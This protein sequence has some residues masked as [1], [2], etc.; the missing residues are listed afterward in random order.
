MVPNQPMNMNMMNMNPNQAIDNFKSMMMTMMMVKVSNQNQNDSQSFKYTILTMFIVYF[1]DVIAT[2]LKTICR[3][4]ESKVSQYVSK[5][6]SDISLIKNLH[7]H[8]IKKKKRSSI[9]IKLEPNAKN[10]FSDAIIDLLTHLPDTK[11]ILLQNGQ[12][13]INYYEHIEFQKN[14]FAK[15]TNSSAFYETVT[16]NDHADESNHATANM[17]ANTNVVKI[18][19]PTT[20]SSGSGGEEKAS[21]E[22]KF[23]HIEI[24]SFEYDMETLRHE[25]DTI[26]KH[27]LIKMTNKLGNGI[28]YF[29]ELTQNTPRNAQGNIDYN[30]MNDS[31]IFTM[32][33][34]ETNRSFDNLFG[35][36]ID[37]I[38]KRVNFFRDNK[39]W[40]DQKGIP[41][42]LGILVSGNPGT[43]KT[44][45]IKCISNEMQRHI[46]N[47]HLTDQMSKQ[48]IE[49]LFFNE[50]IK[51][52]Q[53]GHTDIFT[54]PINRR[55]YVLE[56]IDCQCDIVLERSNEENNETLMKNEIHNL[57]Q[58]LALFQ[59]IWDS[60]GSPQATESLF[61][62]LHA[63]EQLPNT[64]KSGENYDNKITLSFLLNLFDG[65]LETP[66]RI[67]FMTTNFADK[68][69][70]AFIRPGRIDVISNFGF[71][72]PNQ[73]RQIVEHRY[74]TVLSE[75]NVDIINH[76]GKC[77][78][79]AEVSKILFQ[80]FDNVQGAINDLKEYSIKFM[81]D[82]EKKLQLQIQNVKEKED[83]KRI[84]YLEAEKEEDTL[85]IEKDKMQNMQN[86]D[87]MTKLLMKLM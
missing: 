3:F 5:R 70:K 86:L 77:I 6:A 76:L 68:L 22:G 49:N 64:K 54:I 84:E 21:G 38:R 71:S 35:E 74:D 83:A 46:I 18:T 53:N 12:F 59:N 20:S 37:I 2:Q 80:N 79:A 17:N 29:N 13:V 10:P 7:I 52:T 36:E 65:V 61:K 9:L 41:Y 27:Y 40:Y 69:D 30:K 48:Q 32:K 78:T 45:L 8:P 55:I 62:K 16:V 11:C 67:I 44:S 42:T 81:A 34:F 39:D 14:Y 47:V 58:R 75:E 56:D 82:E 60:K 51:V 19:T 50:H 63:L 4:V 1:I 73:I 43:G 85:L 15:L 24:Y 25:L 26:Y 57:K 66:G 31:F 72:T 33:A 28:Y 23:D 87:Q